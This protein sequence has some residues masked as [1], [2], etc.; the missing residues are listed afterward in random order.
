MIESEYER[1]RK[2]DKGGEGWKVERPTSTLQQLYPLENTSVT[3]K[4][5]KLCADRMEI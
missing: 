4:L 2:R 3:Y 1:E 5:I